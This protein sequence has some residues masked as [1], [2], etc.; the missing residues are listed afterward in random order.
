MVKK[1]FS[2]KKIRAIADAISGVILMLLIERAGFE[3]VGVRPA[4]E[5]GC[6]WIKVK[7]LRKKVGVV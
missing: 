5:K 3:V 4:R 7:K 6:Y 2:K 1:K